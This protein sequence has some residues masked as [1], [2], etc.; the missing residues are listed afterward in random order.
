[1]EE[2]LTYFEVVVNREANTGGKYIKIGKA[3][4][5]DSM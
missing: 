2:T 4:E 5:A 1:M 3:L